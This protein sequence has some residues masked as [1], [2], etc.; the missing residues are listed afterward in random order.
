M[1]PD[2]HKFFLSFDWTRILYSRATLFADV[3]SCKYF[4]CHS[5]V[6]HGHSKY[7]VMPLVFRYGTGL[8]HSRYNSQEVGQ[9]A[10]E[11][12]A[13]TFSSPFLGDSALPQLQSGRLITTALPGGGIFAYAHAAGGQISRTQDTQVCCFMGRCCVPNNAWASK[14][15]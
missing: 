12:I 9:K 7:R 1:I 5:I 8:C 10:A 11:S 2:K 13:A 4:G 14:L 3:Y 6:A 15:A